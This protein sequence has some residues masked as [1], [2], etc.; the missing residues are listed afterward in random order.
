MVSE[1]RE[2]W[3]FREAVWEFVKRDLRLRYK[4]SVLGF[5]WSMAA[6]LMRV[7]VITIV[8]R[9]VMNVDAPN[10]SAYLFCA[11]LPWNFFSQAAQDACSCV[12]QHFMLV[13]KVYFPRELLPISSVLANALHFLLSLLVLFVYLA[14]L[15]VHPSRLILLLPV[16]VVIQ[17]V[18]TLGLAF[19]L[20]FLNVYFEDVRYLVANLLQ[21][22]LF[23][24][25]I[26]FPIEKVGATWYRLVMLNPMAGIVVAY[27]KILLPPIQLPDAAALP[28]DWGNLYYTAAV[29]F[30]T[31][32]AGYWLFNRYKWQLAELV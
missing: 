2:L 24:T 31:L 12:L 28:L 21:I 17:C 25:P 13:K 32:I 7:F 16:L 1:L 15:P 4:N 8:M 29:S 10:Y 11:F 9:R 19:M 27:Q 3:R 30:A 26:I 6:P 5:A 18:F 22:L 14:L 20:S 23:A